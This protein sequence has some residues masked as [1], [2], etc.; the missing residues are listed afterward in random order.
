MGDGRWEV[1]DVRYLADTRLHEN[2]SSSLPLLQSVG[3][4]GEYFK[5]CAELQ[6]FHPTG[7]FR[8]KQLK[9]YAKL[10]IRSKSLEIGHRKAMF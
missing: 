9:M 2:G 4:S 3:Q 1:P 8:S 6:I 5:S 7:G 10:N